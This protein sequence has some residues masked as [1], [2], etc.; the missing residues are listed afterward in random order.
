[1][2]RSSGSGVYALVVIVVL[3]TACI[4]GVMMLQGIIGTTD[5]SVTE[6]TD[7]SGVNETVTP[8]LGALFNGAMLPVWILVIAAVCVA[9]YMMVRASKRRR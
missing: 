9:L 1:M 2:R 8:I 4:F 3:I 6:G 7:L 5:S